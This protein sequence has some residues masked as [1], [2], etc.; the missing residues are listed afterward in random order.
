MTTGSQKRKLIAS[1]DHE[2]SPV[3]KRRA[4]LKYRVGKEGFFFLNKINLEF[5]FLESIC[6]NGNFGD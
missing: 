2:L 1:S 6:L 4:L 5:F 3:P